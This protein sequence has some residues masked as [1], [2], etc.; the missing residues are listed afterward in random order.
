MYKIY[1]NVEDKT[2]FNGNERDFIE[3][4]NIIKNENQDVD[5]SIIGISDAIQ[6]VEDYCGNLDLIS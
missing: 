3:F 5:Y 4:M 1:N 6:Y 2:I